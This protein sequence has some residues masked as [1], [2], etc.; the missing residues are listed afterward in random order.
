MLYILSVTSVNEFVFG[1]FCLLF[2]LQLCS[3]TFSQ[4]LLHFVTSSNDVLYDPML[5]N[6]VEW[7]KRCEHVLVLDEYICPGDQ[8]FP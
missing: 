1:D 3:V 4:R 8:L 5:Q 6:S 7:D 2:F